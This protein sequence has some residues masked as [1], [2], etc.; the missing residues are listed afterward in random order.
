MGEKEEAEEHA[1][2]IA[3]INFR[4]RI[5]EQRL[6]RVRIDLE[7]VL[8]LSLQHQN[9]A[10]EK[11]HELKKKL[12]N[13]PRISV[14]LQQQLAQHPQG[15]FILSVETLSY[16]LKHRALVLLIQQTNSRTDCKFSVK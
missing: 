10:G 11:V 16:L 5:L 2:T 13:D 12:I 6:Q 4:K 7:I 15:T 9:N 3:E 14:P 8:L 1:K